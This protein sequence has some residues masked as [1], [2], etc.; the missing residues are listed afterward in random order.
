MTAN[1]PTETSQA[2]QIAG[3]EAFVLHNP[4]LDRL[5]NLLRQF[6]VFE[7]LKTVEVEVRHSNVFAWLLNPAENHG[8]GD[9]FIKQFLKYLVSNN[10]ESIGERMS[11]FDFEFFDYGHVEIRRE[12]KNIDILIVLEDGERSLVVAIENKVR[13]S[14]H[15]NQLQRYREIVDREFPQTKRIYVYLTPENEIPSDV[16][17]LPFDY[18]TVSELLRHLLADRKDSMNSAVASFLSQYDTVLRRYIVGNSEVEQIC[19]QIYKKHQAALDLIFEYKPDIDLEVS[20]HLTSL[21]KD[22]PELIVD[23]AGKTL[24][25]FTTQTIDK[26][27]DKVGEGWTWT[28]RILLFEFN[29]YDRRL[30]LRLYIGPGLPAC[31]IGLRDI[32]LQN[33]KLFNK[34]ERKLGTKWHAVYQREFLKKSDYEE[35]TID[36]LKPQIDA[37]WKEFCEDDLKK[38]AQYVKDHWRS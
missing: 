24:I 6:N 15:S 29:N 35:K 14:E 12:W 38:I 10:R 13:S 1:Q 9:Y 31:R 4:D 2:S 36:D 37:K 23:T 17:W 30:V 21:I 32:F 18:G 22:H 11:L 3:L 26:H 33:T 28:K 16:D 7:T 19:L 5:E 20:D 8:L 34:V 27:V 25:R